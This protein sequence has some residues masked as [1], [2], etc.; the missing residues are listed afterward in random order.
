MSQWNALNVN[1]IKTRKIR[2]AKLNLPT[3]LAELPSKKSTPSP[4]RASTKT[5]NL[6]SHNQYCKEQL[7]Y[8]SADCSISVLSTEDSFNSSITVEDDVFQKSFQTPPEKDGCFSKNLTKRSLSL[9]AYL[10]SEEGYCNSLDSDVCFHPRRLF[11]EA[12][13]LE[14]CPRSTSGRS[15]RAHSRALNQGLCGDSFP[16][17]Q[18]NIHKGNASRTPH[19]ERMKSTDLSSLI[20]FDNNNNNSKSDQNNLESIKSKSRHSLREVTQSKG[21]LDVRPSWEQKVLVLTSDFKF[22]TELSTKPRNESAPRSKSV[23]LTENISTCK[24]HNTGRHVKSETNS[25]MPRLQTVVWDY[26]KRKT[27]K[28]KQKDETSY[29]Q[30]DENV[31]LGETNFKATNQECSSENFQDG[32]VERCKDELQIDLKKYEVDSLGSKVSVKFLIH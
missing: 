5:E 28:R 11:K 2:C 17:L 21:G 1:V 26:I 22:G 19:A 31:N 10:G 6:N 7:N 29:S 23:A 12:L 32:G 18:E 20:T 13:N 24:A 8:S 4:K 9:P 15:N 25:E 16:R 27:T 3:T 14:I 30:K